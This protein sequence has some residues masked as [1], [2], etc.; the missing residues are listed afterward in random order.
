MPGLAECFG[1][2]GQRNVQA[3]GGRQA[4]EG[5]CVAGWPELGVTASFGL[6]AVRGGE[7]SLAP[8]IARGD[9][10]LHGAKRRGRNTVVAEGRQAEPEL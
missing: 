10:S 8:A 2:A 9:R 7:T 6:S 3:C 4:F 1:G 5:L